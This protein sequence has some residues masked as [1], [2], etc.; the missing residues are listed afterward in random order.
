MVVDFLLDK[1]ILFNLPYQDRSNVLVRLE[2]STC[3]DYH[4]SNQ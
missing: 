4:R 3:L 1:A 2:E